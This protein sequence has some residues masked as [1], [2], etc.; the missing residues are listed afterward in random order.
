MAAPFSGNQAASFDLASTDRELRQEHPYLQ[1][2]HTA[3]TLVR[4]SDL[5]VVLIAMKAGA[6]MAEHRVDETAAVHLLQGNLRLRLPG[7]VVELAAGQ[8]LILE[9]AIPHDVEAVVESSF[10]LTLGPKKGT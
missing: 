1:T 4:E 9:R 10:L 5:R 2:G 8:L 7:R 6:R 3:R